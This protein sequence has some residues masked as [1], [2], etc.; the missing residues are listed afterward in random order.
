MLEGDGASDPLQ[1]SDFVDLCGYNIILY[2]SRV[3]DYCFSYEV[4]A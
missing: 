1:E 2:Q 3:L 4:F